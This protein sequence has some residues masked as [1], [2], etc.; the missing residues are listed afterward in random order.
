MPEKGDFRQDLKG[1]KISE[2]ETG[3]RKEQTAADLTRATIHSFGAFHFPVFGLR[4]PVSMNGGF[5][6]ADCHTRQTHAS[7]PLRR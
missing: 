1:L 4:F 7:W 6:R 3:H 2:A 5:S